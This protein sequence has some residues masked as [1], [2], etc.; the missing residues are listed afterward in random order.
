MGARNVSKYSQGKKCAFS[1]SGRNNNKDAFP[2]Q[3]SQILIA[4]QA[5]I[6][7]VVFFTQQSLKMSRKISRKGRQTE[8]R[9]WICQ[10]KTQTAKQIRSESITQSEAT[11]VARY[12]GHVE[13]FQVFSC[14]HSLAHFH[15]VHQWKKFYMHLRIQSFLYVFFL[16]SN[17]N[18]CNS[19]CLRKP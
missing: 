18:L 15:S 1:Q 4:I 17:W 14:L 3:V 13:M 7:V 9:R 8:L 5:I 16:K 10:K 11:N 19:I 2:A 6:V 12:K